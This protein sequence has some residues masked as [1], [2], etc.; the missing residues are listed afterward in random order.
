MKTT[1]RII[2]A[3]INQPA[4]VSLPH[5][6]EEI[7]LI[8]HKITPMTDQKEALRYTYNIL[9]KKYR[10]FRLL[11]FLRLDRLCI[12]DLATLWKINGFLHCHQMNYLLCTILRASKQFAPEDITT[13]WTHIWFVSPHQYLSFRLRNKE[14]LSIDLWAKAYGV[15][16]GDYAHGFNAGSILA[17]SPIK[18]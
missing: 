1:F 16:F 8:V 11:T 18:H 6:P 4:T 2:D 15:P 14:T 3:W 7:R 17:P 9:T 12:T 13:H 5:L 10:G